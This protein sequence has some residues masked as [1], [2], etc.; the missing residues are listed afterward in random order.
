MDKDTHNTS[1]LY[2]K[3]IDFLRK[4]GKF[5]NKYEID[6][7]QIKKSI[8]DRIK[9]S[10]RLNAI[11][12]EIVFSKVGDNT[13]D[14]LDENNSEDELINNEPIINNKADKLINNEPIINNDSN[15]LIFYE[16]LKNTN[17]VLEKGNNK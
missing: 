16:L 12:R 17:I 11:P 6:I 15:E 8:L 5:I 1:L 13:E 2:T 7:N 3:Y 14:E 9:K 4:F 10:C